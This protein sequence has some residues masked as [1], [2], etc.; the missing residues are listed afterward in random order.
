MLSLP[1]AFVSLPLYI[2]VPDFYV[3]SGYVSLS[4]VGFIL[5]FIRLFDAIQDPV[6]GIVFDR[7][8]QCYLAYLMCGLICMVAGFYI[9]FHPVELQ[10]VSF[11]VGMILC[12]L[13]LS[14]VSILFH[15]LGGLWKTGYAYQKTQVTSW[16]KR[17]A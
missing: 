10:I 11:F 12:T 3:S 17:L 15:S 6:I 8:P 14:I 16:R 1:L 4:M 2:Y 5:L 13:G 7:Y 9:V